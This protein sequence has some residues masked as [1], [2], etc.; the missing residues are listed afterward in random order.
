MTMTIM[1]IIDL[2]LTSQEVAGLKII[3]STEEEFMNLIS[4]ILYFYNF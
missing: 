3:L 2:I 4:R 1:S